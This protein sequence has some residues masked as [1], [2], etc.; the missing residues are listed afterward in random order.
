MVYVID[1]EEK[2]NLD[3]N[4]FKGTSEVMDNSDEKAR[5]Y[6]DSLKIKKVNIGSK[7]KPKEAI[8]GDYWLEK[9]GYKVIE[10]F[11][12]FQDL[13]PRG[14]HELICVHHS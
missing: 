2:V 12:K 9:E 5:A 1:G 3:V 13:F 11:Q 10:I 14:Y 8:I 6:H 7:E 4:H